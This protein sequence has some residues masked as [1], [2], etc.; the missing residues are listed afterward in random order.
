MNRSKKDKYIEVTNIKTLLNILITWL[1]IFFKHRLSLN[2][3][4]V[5]FLHTSTQIYGSNKLEMISFFKLHDP[6]MIRN[7]CLPCSQT[8]RLATLSFLKPAFHPISLR[9]CCSKIDCKFCFLFR[10]DN[11]HSRKRGQSPNEF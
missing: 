8:S 3:A 5:S 4:H 10:Q 9:Q 11:L 6:F 1:K 7:F 2:G